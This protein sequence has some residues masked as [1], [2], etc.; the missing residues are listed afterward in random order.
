MC[1]TDIISLGEPIDGKK[2]ENYLDLAKIWKM[3]KINI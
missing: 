3:S 1:G 2:K